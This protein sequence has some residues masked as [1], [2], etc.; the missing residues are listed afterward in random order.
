MKDQTPTTLGAEPTQVPYMTPTK[1]PIPCTKVQ[2]RTNKL[3]QTSTQVPYTTQM[4]LTA[5]KP[6]AHAACYC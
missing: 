6:S 5:F 2:C 1:V 3:D 4:I